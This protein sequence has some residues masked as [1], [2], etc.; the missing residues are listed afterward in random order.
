MWQPRKALV[1]AD[2]FCYRAGFATND[3]PVEEAIS[4]FNHLVA[5]AVLD[6]GCVEYQLYITGKTNFRNDVAKTAVYKGNRKGVDKPIHIDALRDHAMTAWEAIMSDGEEAD[7]LIAIEATRRGVLN[8]IIV[9]VDKDFL[10]VPGLFYNPVK[11]QH[12]TVDAWSGLFFFYQQILMG[13]TADNIIGLRGI[14]PAKAHKIL[15]G[16]EDELELYHR[17]VNAYDG[18]VDRVIENARLLWLRRE[19]GQIWEPPNGR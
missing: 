11:K 19:P 8:S 7:D 17:C 15:T 14:G 2:I 10:Q 1:D 3:E 12:I 6:S 16:S 5:S 4:A 18:D 9:S 13:D